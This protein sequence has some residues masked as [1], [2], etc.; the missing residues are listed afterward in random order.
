MRG[1]QFLVAMALAG[2]L[3]ATT[4]EAQASTD[5]ASSLTPCATFLNATTK[6]PSS[7]C[8]PLK[9]AIETEKDCL[10]NIFNT[11]GLLKSFGI[12]VTEATQLPRKCEIPGTS[13]NMCTSAPSSSPAANTTSPPPSAGKAGGRISWSGVLGFLLMGTSLLVIY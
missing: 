6:P 4:S 8:D 1:I 2:A 10:C 13:I 3:I 5:C 9:K 12:N 11:P 7:C